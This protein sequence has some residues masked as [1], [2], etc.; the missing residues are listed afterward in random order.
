MDL[1]LGSVD[2]MKIVFPD[3]VVPDC[4]VV[5]WAVWEIDPD[6]EDWVDWVVDPV[7]VEVWIFDPEVDTDVE[8]WMFDPEVDPE[9]V[10]EVDPWLLTTV[11]DDPAPDW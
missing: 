9:P 1:Q 4:W 2:V 8:V 10:P 11:F 3:E 6:V 5:T 7:E